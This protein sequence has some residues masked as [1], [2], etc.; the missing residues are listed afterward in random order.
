MKNDKKQVLSRID[1]FH[2]EELDENNYKLIYYDQEGNRAEKPIPKDLLESTLKLFDGKTHLIRRSS[3]A[4]SPATPSQ[5]LIYP[6][7][8]AEKSNENP[9]ELLRVNARFIDLERDKNGQIVSEKLVVHHKNVHPSV[10]RLMTE[11]EDPFRH[12]YWIDLGNEITPVTVFD[13]FR[14][15]N[16][17][18]KALFVKTDDLRI[19][20]NQQRGQKKQIAIYS[21][22]EAILRVS[23]PE[24][25]REV[26]EQHTLTKSV[27]SIQKMEKCEIPKFLTFGPP[28]LI[29]TGAPL[30]VLN[31]YLRICHDPHAESLKQSF[32]SVLEKPKT[33]DEEELMPFGLFERA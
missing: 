2:W 22:P 29:P 20:S 11:K 16:E 27:A 12:Q 14:G 25:S 21:A 17:I 30:N 23:L 28:Q 10:F 19:I 5:L 1:C 26:V 15:E 3:G 9:G 24:E 18:I 8:N 32:L 31:H 4:Y 6:K 7:A 33:I 13:F